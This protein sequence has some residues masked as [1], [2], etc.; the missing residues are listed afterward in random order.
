MRLI[1]ED[2]GPGSGPSPRRCGALVMVAAVAGLVGTACSGG[3]VE[4]VADRSVEPTVA[5]TGE[6]TGNLVVPTLPASARIVYAY[7]PTV[8]GKVRRLDVFVAD[9]DGNEVKLTDNDDGRQYEH[10]AISDDHRY[11][12]TNYRYPGPDG[13]SRSQMSVT[14][15]RNG[16]ERAIADDFLEAGNGGVDWDRDGWI[17]FMA[18]RPDD[19]DA[20]AIYRARHDGSAVEQLTDSGDFDADVSVSEDGTMITFVRRSMSPDG[21]F[22]EIWVAGADGSD[23]RSVYRSGAV[24]VASAHDPEFSFDNRSVVFSLTNSTVP[25]N[26]PSLENTAHDICVLELGRTEPDCITAPGGISIIPDWHQDGSILFTEWREADGY[27]GLTVIDE[28][29]SEPVRLGFGEF[30]KWIPNR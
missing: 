16:E 10:A 26:Y 20:S 18:V 6:T 2:I 12:L 22:T 30:A 7:G 29:G 25:P 14:D 9:L 17:Y 4:P 27:R 19:G 13:L 1:G 5:A 24:G 28:D 15:L 8:D 3:G 21:P 11:L 23:P